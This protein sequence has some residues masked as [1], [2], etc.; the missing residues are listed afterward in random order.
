MSAINGDVPR[1]RQWFGRV[2]A[3]DRTFFDAAERAQNLA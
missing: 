2:V 3:A 1:A